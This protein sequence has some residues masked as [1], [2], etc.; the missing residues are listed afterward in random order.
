[1]DVAAELARVVGL[2]RGRSNALRPDDLLR[3]LASATTVDGRVV[4]RGGLEVAVLVDP[5]DQLLAPGQHL[6]HVEPG[7]VALKDVARDLA[8]AV[9]VAALVGVQESASAGAVRDE[10]RQVRDEVRLRHG[11]GGVD[12]RLEALGRQL[13][14]HELQRAH[15][16][17]AVHGGL[18]LPR[19]AQAPDAGGRNLGR[20]D[21]VPGLVE[22]LH[23]ILGDLRA[24]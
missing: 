7:D 10:L 23:D 2:G 17:P 20:D 22:D 16:A 21:D 1:V 14:V 12:A 8:D 18:N 5:V 24:L 11:L 13:T 19:E 3:G 15:A 4:A 6:G 9:D